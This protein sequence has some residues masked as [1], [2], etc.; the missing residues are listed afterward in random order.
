MNTKKISGNSQ[1]ATFSD[2]ARQR[3]K[4]V[5]RENNP[6][7]KYV[8]GGH[9][10]SEDLRIKSFGV[11]SEGYV[12][13]AFHRLF[14]RGNILYGSRRTYL[15][16]IAVADFDGITSNTTFVIEPKNTNLLCG[17]LL[18][19]LMLTD[20]FTKH[21]VLNSKGSTNPYVNWSDLEKF[22]FLV[23]SKAKQKSILNILRLSDLS[24]YTAEAAKISCQALQ[25]T[26]IHETFVRKAGWVD[27][28]LGELCEIKGGRQRSPKYEAGVNPIKYLR[29]ANIKKGLFRDDD[30]KE[31]DFNAEELI[32]Y[33]LAHGDILL[34]E[35][36]EETD[37]G[38]SLFWRNQI[39]G[40]VAFQNTL[41]RLRADKARISSSALY[42]LMVY[43]HRFGHFRSIAAGTKIKHIGSKKTSEITVSL[44]K[45]LDSIDKKVCL[46]NE[47]DLHIT[48]LDNKIAQAKNLR[49]R[50]INKL[51]G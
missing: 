11:F 19:Y 18:P 29:P 16:K 42:W 8:E 10:E 37:V 13:P 17:D 48:S 32:N 25:M 50:L 44:P 40:P 21:S 9:I 2:V 51:L 3:K 36:G 30:I 12:G 35:G 49:K 24:V 28:R 23:P 7:E 33:S 20:N 5:D 31:M 15:K 1:K 6:F 27:Y 38:D 26:L 34:V 46:L 4:S 41:L 39:E 45:N 14:E 47:I 43:M 22:T